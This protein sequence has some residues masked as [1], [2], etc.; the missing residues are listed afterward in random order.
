MK[1]SRQNKTATAK[2]KKPRQ[3]KIAIFGLLHIVYF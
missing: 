2:Q 3:N 1:H